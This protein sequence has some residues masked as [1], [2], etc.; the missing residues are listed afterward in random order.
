MTTSLRPP[1]P[2]YGSKGRLARWIVDLMP[3][4]R[5]YVEPFAGSAAVLFAKPAAPV[6]IINDLDQNVVAFFRA[7]REREPELLRALRL[8]PYSRDEF[9]AADLSEP[10]LNDV[11][12]ARRFFVRTTQ[13]HN[14]AGSGGRAGWSNGIRERHTDATATTTLVDRLW[15]LAERLRPVVVEH[16]DA[17]EVIAAHDAPDAVFY[18]DP[19]YLSGTRRSG[20][21]YAHEADGEAFH[22]DLAATLASVRGTVLLS[23]YPS[24]LYDELYADWDRVQVAVHRAATNRRGRTGVE[25]GIETVWSNRPLGH[26]DLFS[27][28][29]A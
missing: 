21:D 17:A 23:G 28:G 7:L 8:T 6:E 20:R 14:A 1:F 4:H 2:Y 22:R 18:L 29:E 27:G 24:A 12:R 5:V 10:D 13:G 9:D 16:R 11:E 25:R 15:H 26:A 3:R 19:P